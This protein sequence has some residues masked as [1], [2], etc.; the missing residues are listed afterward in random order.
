MIP[1][2]LWPLEPGDARFD[3]VDP[4]VE[5]V[6]MCESNAMT[7]AWLRLLLVRRRLQRLGDGWTP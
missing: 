7:S 2:P 3:V 6:V 1:P 5:Q 4:E